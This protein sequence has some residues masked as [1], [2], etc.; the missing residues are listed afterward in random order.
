MKRRLLKLLLRWK[1]HLLKLLPLKLHLLTLLHLL[2]MPLHLLLPLPLPSNSG[3]RNKETGLWAGFF[4]VCTPGE[5]Q[6]FC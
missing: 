4:F 5:D 1:L 2:L 6:R 3:L